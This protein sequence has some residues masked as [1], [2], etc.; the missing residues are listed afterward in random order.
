MTIPAGL[1]PPSDDPDL[2]ELKK[3]A[4]CLLLVGGGP[5]TVEQLAEALGAPPQTV[6]ALL[7]ELQQDYGSR[8]L[9][10]QAVAG[11][12]QLCTRPE[13]AQYVQQFLRLDHREPLS[14][15]ALET[16]AIIAYRQPITRAEIEAVRGVRSDHVIDR[17]LERHLAR[18]VGRKQTLGRPFLYGTTEGFLRHFG[19]QDLE[20][21]PALEGDDPRRAFSGGPPAA[22][23]HE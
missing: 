13:L 8:G 20:G 21:L 9:Q 3:A 23:P 17:L 1:T 16:L 12:Y 5:V 7:W 19:L 22:A 15:A 18:E 2:E 10:I 14:Q 6:H 11:G 4:E